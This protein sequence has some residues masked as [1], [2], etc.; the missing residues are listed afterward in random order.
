MR[1]QNLAWEKIRRISFVIEKH[2]SLVATELKFLYFA[3]K[4][5]VLNSFPSLQRHQ[6]ASS[7]LLYET[8]PQDLPSYGS[9]W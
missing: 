3:E 2:K 8:Q 9:H 6:D 5:S 7:S 4:F 1:Y